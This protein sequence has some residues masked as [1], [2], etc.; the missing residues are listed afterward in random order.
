MAWPPVAADLYRHGAPQEFFSGVSA[1]AISA[2]GLAALG[3]CGAALSPRVG[4][5][6][7]EW[8][9][10]STSGQED[11]TRDVCKVWAAELTFALGLV[12]PVQQT[13][14]GDRTFNDRAKAVRE[15]WRRMGTPGG[16]DPS[17]AE[18]LYAGLV[19]ATPAV[20]EGKA[21]GWST[22]F[23]EVNDEVEA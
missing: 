10:T 22:P 1:A 20:T 12:L 7:E 18:P 21:R 19:D 8:T 23:S 14:D 5:P 2:A 13:V 9:F 3:E 17:K 4:G 6:P 11:A 15:R 16:K